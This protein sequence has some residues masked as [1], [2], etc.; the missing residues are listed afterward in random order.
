MTSLEGSTGLVGV[1]RSVTTCIRSSRASF[2]SGLVATFQC[3]INIKGANCIKV[4]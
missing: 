3:N 1:L 2:S 4:L